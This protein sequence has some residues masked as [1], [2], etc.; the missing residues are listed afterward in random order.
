MVE[1]SKNED[2]EKLIH[3]NGG[4]AATSVQFSCSVMSDSLSPHGMQHTRLP[5][6]SPTPIAYSNSWPS[7][8]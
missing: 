8:Q 3:Y 2:Q 7:C 1:A 6:P 5:Y 4:T